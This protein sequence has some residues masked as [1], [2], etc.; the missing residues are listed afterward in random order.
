MFVI[1]DLLL[2][3]IVTSSFFS[4]CCCC[5]ILYSFSDRIQF[6]RIDRRISK[7]IYI[8]SL[9]N[10]SPPFH[11][12]FFLTRSKFIER[13]I[14][15]IHSMKWIELNT[16]NKLCIHIHSHYLDLRCDINV[17]AKFFL[18]CWLNKQ[19]KLYCNHW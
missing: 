4:C 12:F 1:V 2:F 19:S 3:V 15:N 9:V 6:L 7:K 18:F 13:F 17:F 10:L 5:H 11:T 16:V 8:I 14:F